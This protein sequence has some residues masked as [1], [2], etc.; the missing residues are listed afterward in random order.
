MTK[1][2][3]RLFRSERGWAYWSTFFAAFYLLN[4]VTGEAKDLWWRLPLVAGCIV[5]A[6]GAWRSGIRVG[7]TG[8]SIRRRSRAALREWSWDEI[9]SFDH[10]EARWGGDPDK[11]RLQLF[12]RD[13]SSA[14]LP[15]VHEQARLAELLSERLG[16][17]GPRRKGEHP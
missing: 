12:F 11:G 4:A 9:E 13:N 14:D 3:N 5:F 1:E 16:P 15:A 10:P 17:P 2:P 6:L 7:P 8:I